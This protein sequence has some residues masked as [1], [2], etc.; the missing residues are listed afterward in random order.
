[1]FVVQYEHEN[2]VFSDRCLQPAAMEPMYYSSAKHRR[3]LIPSAMIRRYSYLLSIQEEDLILKDLTTI[4]VY[5]VDFEL[6]A[7]AIVYVSNEMNVLK[8]N[9]NTTEFP[10][11]QKKRILLLPKVFVKT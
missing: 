5:V 11:E 2:H 10:T 9:K 4:S 7:I 8:Q 3:Q 1:M 6:Y